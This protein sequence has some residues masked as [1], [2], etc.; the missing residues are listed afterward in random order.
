VDPDGFLPEGIDVTKEQAARIADKYIGRD[1][2]PPIREEDPKPK[3]KRK[4]KGR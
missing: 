2:G 1:G 4:K 3:A